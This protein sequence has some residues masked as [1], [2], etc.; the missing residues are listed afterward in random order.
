MEAVIAEGGVCEAALAV[1]F[2]L[3]RGFI[4]IASVEDNGPSWRK[5]G[6]VESQVVALEVETA[7]DGRHSEALPVREVA[8]TVA[9]AA[10]DI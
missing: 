7:E 1:F 10:G 8:G 6:V 5:N 4:V 2:V 9:H 3:F